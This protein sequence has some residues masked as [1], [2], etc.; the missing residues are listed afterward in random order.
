M[1]RNKILIAVLF[2]A[3]TS[4]FLYPLKY[5]LVLLPLDL[6]VS[7]YGPWF[8]AGQILLK[9]PYMQDAITQYYPWHHAVFEAFQSGMLPFWNP[10]QMMG[11][12]LM[13]G[14]K[15]MTFY[16]T[17]I[18]LIFGE[19]W[20]WHA[21]IFLQIFLGLIFVYALCREF[22]LTRP[23]SI[24]SAFSFSLS[25]WMI[26][27]SEFVSDAHAMLWFPLFIF[28]AKRIIDKKG[29]WNF[30]GL[31]L[32]IT[33]S[34][35]AGQLQYTGYGLI[36]LGL[37][38][39]YYG[40]LEKIKLKTYAI[41]ST[42][43]LLGILASSV[44]LFP[45]LEFF[46]NSYRGLLH[47]HYVYSADLLNVNNLFRL[48]SPDFFGNPTERNLTAG[49][50]EGSGYIGI[51][52]IFFALYAMLFS[53]KNK[54]VRFFTAIFIGAI[55]FSIKGPAAELLY[56][57][58]IPLITSGSGGRTFLLAIIAGSVLSGFG[59]EEFL[60]GKLK[61]NLLSIL[62]FLA[63]FG[64]GILINHKRELF[65]HDIQFQV[66]IFA[67]F[68]A[69]FIAFVA[70]TKSKIIKP[71]MLN[72]AFI[73][74]ILALTFLD[75]FRFGYRYLTFSNSK[76]LYPDTEITSY[77]KDNSKENLARSFGITDPEIST[78]MHIYSLE[79]YAPFYPARSAKLLQALQ[80]QPTNINP[81]DNKYFMTKNPDLKYALDF[82]GVEFVAGPKDFN[83]SYFYFNTTDYAPSFDKIKSAG[84]VD[85]YKNKD[86]LPRFSLYYKYQTARSE[87]ELKIIS[88]RKFDP[89][90]EILLEEKIPVSL[91]D[92]TGSARLI[93]SN[94][95]SQTFEVKTDK[96][97]LFFISD[98]YF[99]G[100]SAKVNGKDSKIYRANYNLRAVLVPAGSSTINFSY[101]PT[102]FHL[103]ESL[104]LLSAFL[105]IALSF[106]L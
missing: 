40:K 103:Y 63:L 76:F 51:I 57:L 53:L 74:A 17:N 31:G 60:K 75:L 81:Q 84:T 13:A 68:I 77:I 30:L 8:M 6:L 20:Q 48:F 54:A 101:L 36:L 59:F 70:V 105:L 99:P 106:L 5:G 72:N 83:P 12:P 23:A 46:S 21:S 28:F 62:G 26:G 37:F 10:Y 85:L 43:V 55:L 49:Y 89:K 3:L 2:F 22:K 39:L 88:E 9:N 14:I 102:H 65:F 44:Q 71:K 56:L 19:V 50:I 82:M 69:S 73:L 35:F 29:K 38:V 93:S 18:L 90:T 104:S 98:T 96:E 27:L 79:T 45:A 47:S 25:S 91:E 34:I 80:K 52:S 41:I 100:W 97:G 16:P 87:E 66:L 64:I 86:A 92:G 42:S 33:F 58:K 4:F 11:M 67:A 1:N 78:Y 24:L 61:K 95:N 94:V 7:N 15:A 32:S